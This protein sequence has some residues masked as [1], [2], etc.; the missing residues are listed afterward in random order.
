MLITVLRYSFLVVVLAVYNDQ[1]IE[2]PA[3]HRHVPGNN[4][5][6]C[7]AIMNLYIGLSRDDKWASVRKLRNFR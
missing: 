2:K 5:F 1:S 6:V 4:W 7:R 3:I